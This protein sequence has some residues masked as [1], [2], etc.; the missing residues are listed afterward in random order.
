MRVFVEQEAIL[1]LF[2]DSR[3]ATLSAVADLDWAL[4]LGADGWRGADV[5]GH[6]AAW[7]LEAAR[8]LAAHQSGAA[9]APPAAREAFNQAVF[10]Q[11]RQAAPARALADWQ[12]ARAELTERVLA[13]E[14][15]GYGRR[16]DSA[17]GPLFIGAL[18]K[19]LIA[20]EQAHIRAVL[21]AAGRDQPYDTWGG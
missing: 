1:T 13:L 19:R 2:E 17:D 9:Y 7:E 16:L 8:A 4:P 15:P 18:A 3:A 6:L 20:H 5:L 14:W 10:E 21:R 12:A 11:A